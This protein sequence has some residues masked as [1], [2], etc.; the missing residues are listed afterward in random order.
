ML[1]SE[2]AVYKLVGPVLAKQDVGEAKANVQK[3]IEYIQKEIVRM[4]Q[5]EG[6]FQGKVEDKKK[7]IQ[8]FQDDYRKLVAQ[9]QA[10]QK[11]Q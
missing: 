2:A 11:Q 5:L 6:D 8:R 9:A 7:N 10:A 3:R 1:E 4:E